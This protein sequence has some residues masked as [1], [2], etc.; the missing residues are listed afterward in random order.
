MYTNSSGDKYG[1][2]IS[3][4]TAAVAAGVIV[5]FISI[6]LLLG[7]L[8]VGIRVKSKRRQP[9]RKVSAVILSVSEI[10]ILLL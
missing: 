4:N 8:V 2:S 6:L 1:G 5:P 9:Q 7:I 10:I 3:I